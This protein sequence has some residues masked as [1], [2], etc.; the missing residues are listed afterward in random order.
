MLKIRYQ[1]LE[2]HTRMNKK[3]RQKPIRKGYCQ[4]CGAK[5]SSARSIERGIGKH[6]LI[7]NVAIVLE[8]IPDVASNKACTRL[9]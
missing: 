5:L 7:H 9:G 8:I 2:P 6:C 1:I 4:V 3:H